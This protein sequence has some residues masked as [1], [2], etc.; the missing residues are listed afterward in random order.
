M[1]TFT[2]TI[3]VYLVFAITLM[4]NSKAQ[5]NEQTKIDKF[6]TSTL[7]KH[8]EIPGLAISIIKYGKPFFT[9]AYGYSDLKSK[10]T[11]NLQTS[12]YIASVTK[13]FV[14][15]MA[16]QLEEEV[17][18]N[19]DDPITKFAPIKNFKDNSVFKNISIRDLL[20]HTS[21][22]RNGLLTWKYASIGEYTVSQMITI[23]K[24]K[25]GSR[26]NNKSYK[27]D[28]LGYNIFDLILHEEFNL[29]WK[30]VLNN[31]IFNPLKMNHS[32]SYL[33]KAKK[34]NWDL[35]QPYTSLDKDNFPKLVLTKKN[36][37]TFQ[38]AG[39]MVSSI[40]DMQ[41]WL[42]MYMNSGTLSGKQLFSKRAISNTLIPVTKNE[43][44]GTIFNNKG[45]GLG[46]NIGQF[47]DHKVNYH[48]G[49]FDGY[50]AHASFLPE[51]NIGIV[52]LANENQFGDNVSNLIA[53]FSYDLLLNNL[54]EIE[55]YDKQFQNLTN[56]ITSVQTAYKDDKDFR[57]NRKWTLIHDFKNYQGTYV[58]KTIGSIVISVSNDVMKAKLGISEAIA[59]PSTKDD[60]IR[61]EFRDG[62]G[63]DILFISDESGTLAAVFG[64]NVY[65]KN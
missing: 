55:G 42:L 51:E 21:G 38:A 6:I 4:M 43:Q 36:D 14:G 8:K 49:G 57:A 63:T 22:I 2:K 32:T 3:V 46:W 40:E 18:F 59:S 37:Q 35:A 61:V 33:S 41:Q 52:I 24:N 10:N 65:L 47:G 26:Y 53:S 54:S 17:L 23:L 48:F 7:E 27:Y 34:S 5:T 39:G 20:S 28:N 30:E 19:L 16:A 15:L 13:S 11:T 62:Q 64:G 25:T 1:M 56:K 12:Y 9:K 58:N 31:K 45:Y 60:S 29:N 50:F 44:Q